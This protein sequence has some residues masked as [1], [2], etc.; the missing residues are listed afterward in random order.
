MDGHEAS[1]L[2]PYPLKLLPSIEGK[3]QIWLHRLG[4]VQIG[5]LQPVPV[6]TLSKFM[7]QDKAKTVLQ[8][9]RGEDRPRLPMLADRPGESRHTWRIEPPA[10]PKEVPLAS[11]LL[12]KLWRD[13]RNPQSIRLQWWDADGAAHRWKA[14]GNDLTEPPMVIARTAEAIFRQESERRIIVHRL[15]AV[16]GWGLGRQ[17]GLFGE[18]NRKLEAIE[19]ALARLRARFPAHPVLPGWAM[20]AASKGV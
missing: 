11:W 18:C 7:P 17:R 14:D 3:T 10:V 6:A 20:A 9:A 2:A 8:C 12:D 13:V 19:P 5:D 1:Y 16:I 15:E 4:L